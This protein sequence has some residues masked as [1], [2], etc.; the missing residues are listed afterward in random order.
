LKSVA[1]FSTSFQAARRALDWC[2]L[3]H[4]RLHQTRHNQEP[5]LAAPKES[6][7]R[8]AVNCRNAFDDGQDAK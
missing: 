8:N 3:S 5:P 4:Q 2:G 6:H 1:F 7:L